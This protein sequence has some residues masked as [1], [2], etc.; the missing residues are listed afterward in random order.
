MHGPYI[1]LIEHDTVYEFGAFALTH[2]SRQC[3]PPL[4]SHPGRTPTQDWLLSRHPQT[5]LRNLYLAI[6]GSYHSYKFSSNTGK[7]ASKT[8][9]GKGNV[10]DKDEAW[11]WE[12][13]K[14]DGQGAHPKTETN[15]TSRYTVEPSFT[16]VIFRRSESPF[17]ST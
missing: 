14:L 10:K 15:A 16:Y 8:L 13:G 11:A 5:S 17:S 4:L 12:S 3:L 9:S 2:R 1:A 6:E 7:Y